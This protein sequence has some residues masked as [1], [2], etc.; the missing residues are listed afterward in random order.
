MALVAAE[1]S[2]IAPDGLGFPTEYRRTILWGWAIIAISFGGLVLWSALAP[3]GSAVIAAGTVV[4]DSARKSVQHL[5]GGII[6]QIL[7]RDGD[8]VEAGQPLIRLD[9]T[10][11]RN[12]L[13][14]LQGRLDGDRAYEARLIAE[15]DRREEIEFPADLSGRAQVS[16]QIRQ[17]LAGQVDI[18]KARR[19][20]LAGQVSILKNRIEQSNVEIGGLT[21]QETSKTSQAELLRRE[22]AGQQTLLTKGY[23]AEN[24]VLAVERE[25]AQVEGERGE[26]V[27][28]IASVRQAIG[29]SQLQIVQLEKA[30]LE[31]VQDE[32]RK[33]QTEIFDLAQRVAGAKEQIDRLLIGAPVSGVVVDLA[34]HT[35]G[36]VIAAGSRILDVVPRNDALVVEA[37]VRPGDIN[38]LKVGLPT[39]IRFPAFQHGTTPVIRGA[40]T[41]VSA[42]RLLDARTNVPYYLVR[43][44]VPQG[45]RQ[46]L[47]GLQLVPG[48]PAEVIVRKSDHTLLQ[49]L[50]GPIGDVIVRAFRD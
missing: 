34:V 44:T 12:S 43:V 21:Q 42:D 19:S 50:L 49:Y 33:T 18:F 26:I 39:D 30:F 47:A 35:V 45:E 28:R 3:L 15:R 2:A 23:A 13:D 32:L 25:V 14:L 11:Q 1:P 17:M 38:D 6:R 10:I 36:G 48:M 7:V 22:L 8:V 4:V 46:K 37:Q 27:A 5:E 31:S 40:V 9:D 20:T 41:V 24:K 29:E 16:S